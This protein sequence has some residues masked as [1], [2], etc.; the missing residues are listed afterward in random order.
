MVLKRP[1]FVISKN[2]A[3]HL[4]QLITNVNLN[5]STLNFE[6]REHLIINWYNINFV[7]I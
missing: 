1:L 6:V 3:V 4:R 2:I 5:Y 7:I